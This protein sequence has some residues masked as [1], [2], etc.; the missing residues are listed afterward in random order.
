MKFK[1][2]VYTLLIVLSLFVIVISLYS[3]IFMK[4]DQGYTELFF[5]PN[6]YSDIIDE[7]KNV[8][9]EYKIVNNER[10]ST[11]YN[12]DFFY[13]TKK[14]DNKNIFLDVGEEYHEKYSFIIT[15]D[16]PLPV[17]VSVVLIDFNQSINFWIWEIR[18]E[19]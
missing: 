14:I 3:V 2:L 12:I 7:D 19:E 5:I 9:F 6:S 10:E 18:S 1:N 4:K 17:N 16:F 11:I 15:D 13:G 8:S